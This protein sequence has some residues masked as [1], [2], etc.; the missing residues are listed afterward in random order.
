MYPLK[1]LLSIK[2]P[3]KIGLRPLPI[4]KEKEKSQ[5]INLVN[6]V[7][8]FVKKDFKKM[9][10]N[11]LGRKKESLLKG[12]ASSSLRVNNSLKNTSGDKL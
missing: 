2:N 4:R 3:I 10:I 12:K 6:K 8:N 11:N 9:Y 5:K 1:S 7:I